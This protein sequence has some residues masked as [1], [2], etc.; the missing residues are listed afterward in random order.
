[1]SVL[2]QSEHLENIPFHYSVPTSTVTS[3]HCLSDLL[4]HRANLSED[5][6]S[7][8]QDRYLTFSHS[9]ELADYFS[10]LAQT[11]AAHSYTAQPNGVLAPALNFDHLSSAKAAQKYRK[12]FSSAIQQDL[13]PAGEVGHFQDGHLSVEPQDVGPGFDTV[14]YPLLQMGYYGIRQEEMATRKLLEELGR[15]ERLCIASGYFN[16]PPQYTTALLQAEGSCSILAASPQV[17]C[18]CHHWLALFACLKAHA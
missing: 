6:F 16:L 5:Y 1:M 10:T 12:L 13:I 8:R 3:L 17:G 14:V 9:P 2:S 15:E 18:K 4:L 7:D 11:I